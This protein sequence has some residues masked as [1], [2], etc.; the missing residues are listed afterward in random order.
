MHPVTAVFKK[1]SSSFH[2][3]SKGLRLTSGFL[4]CLFLLLPVCL[5]G[6]QGSVSHWRNIITKKVPVLADT[7]L[8]DSLSIAP[9]SFHITGISDSDYIILPGAAK[10]TWKKRPARDS[11]EVTYR[12]LA[13]SLHHVY[14]HKTPGLVDSNVPFFIYKMDDGLNGSGRFVDFNQLDYNGSYGRSIAL[15]NNQDVVLNSNFNLQANGYIL[16]SVQLEAAITDNTIP[17]Q[18]EGNT[19]RIQEFDQIYIRLRKDKHSLILGDYNLERPPGYFLNFYKR[20]QG[21]YYQ[22]EMPLGPATTNKIGLSGSVAKGQFARNIFQGQEGNQGPYKLTGNNGEQFFIVLAATER[23]YIDDV[24]MER[25]ENADYIINYNTA[26][27]RFMPRRLISKDTR[28]QV[29][30]EYQDRNYLNSLIFAYDE[31]QI[32]KKWNIRVNAYSN[33]DAKNQPYLQNL[34]GEQKRFLSAIGDSTQNAFY[35]V[36]NT[37]TF[38]ANKILYKIVDTTV[39]GIFYDSVFVYSTNPDS[40]I[41]NLSFAYVG[42]ER[43]NYTISGTNANGRV[44]DWIA[45]LNGRRRGNFEPVQLLIAPKMQQVFTVNT[46]YTIDSFK[47]VNV[48]LATSNTDPNLY[49]KIDNQTHWGS[50]AKITYAERRFF[51]TK[52]TLGK[53]KWT[54]KNNLSYEYVQNRFQAIAP[55]RNVE[56]GRDWNVPQLGKKPDEHLAT[57]ATSIANQKLGTLGYSFSTYKRGSFYDGNRN[58]VN[59]L[60]QYRKLRSGFVLNMLQATDTFQT[61]RFWRP[62]VFAEYNFKRVMNTFLGARYE[63][64]DNVTRHKL[65]DTLRFN[66]FSFDITTL[67]LRTGAQPIS[68]GINAYRRRDRLPRNNEF[69]LQS[70]SDNLALNLGLAKWEKHQVNLTGTYRQ[71]HITDTTFSNQKPEE[72][73][74]A[75]IDYTGL[76]VKDVFSINTL[77][78]VGAGQEQKRSYT[79]IEVPAGQGTHTWNDYNGDGVQQ[80]NEF[81]VALYPDQKR[82]IRV[83]LP[84]NEYV[85]V[86]YVNYNQVLGIEPANFWLDRSAK[87]RWQRFVSRFSDQLSLQISNRLLATGLE[88]FNPFIDA[89]ADTAIILTNNALSNTVYFNR[90]SSRWGL[91]HNYLSNTGKQLLNYGLEGNTSKQHLGKLRWNM[92]RT[93]TLNLLGRSGYREYQSAL[94][95]GRTYH[96]DNWSGEPSLTWLY[97]SIIRITGSLRYDE[98]KNQ[99]QYGNELAIIRSANLEIRYTKP[100]IGAIQMRGTYSGISFNGLAASPVAFTMLD[101]LQKGNNYLW[102][103]N[104]DRRVA[105]GIEI[106]FEYEGR[107]AGKTPAIH[108]GRMS[109]RAIL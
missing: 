21:L 30:F 86:N 46:T 62:S 95:D 23:V 97:R 68:W 31:L 22:T 100:A 103:M 1:N 20:V 47:A 104:W 52:D 26:E 4:W 84:T 9:G 35:P 40:A 78:E 7:L 63:L 80:G 29:E 87:R 107:I 3:N 24:L 91:E 70:Y 49:S 42:E 16:D 88:A 82:Y 55:Y 105:K 44:Y 64:E 36:I 17:F 11:V 5:Y 77:Y 2:Q 57:I 39:N 76:A 72:S 25:G 65:A 19:Q 108:T 32:G 75:R 12:T 58:V 14:A 74:V 43:G 50:A 101:A 27:I 98:R 18:P 61:T 66:A 71:L 53:S 81:E 54:W 96:V 99:P 33:Q 41:Y 69:I 67:Y 15:G 79:Y 90:T 34:N 59:Y 92:T 48:E 94:N 6:Q 60:Y 102:Y 51:G 45:P 56:F 28:I 73:I 109:I 93:W 85:K 37:D 89:L 10:L 38:A 13:I 106:S 8:L 83:F